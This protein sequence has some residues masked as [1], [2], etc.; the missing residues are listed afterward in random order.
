[1]W[2]VKDGTTIFELTGN[3]SPQ[4]VSQI[5]PGHKDTV[6]QAKF[7]FDGKLIATG[8]YDGTVKIWD[9]PTG[10]MAANLEGPSDLIEVSPPIFFPPKFD[11][12]LFVGIPK[13]MQFWREVKTIRFG[14]GWLRV[15]S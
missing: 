9:V 12:R 5:F 1:L 7:N 6:S 11:F 14:C 8:S 10:K 13:E 2:N 4:N 15:H 3:A